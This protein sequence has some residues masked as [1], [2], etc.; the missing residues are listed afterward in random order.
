MAAGDDPPVPRGTHAGGGAVGGEWGVTRV[1][2]VADSARGEE[3]GEFHGRLF[4]A[5]VSVIAVDA[6]PGAAKKG[7]SPQCAAPV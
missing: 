3:S 1:L 5:S 6:L 7:S 2:D 4:G